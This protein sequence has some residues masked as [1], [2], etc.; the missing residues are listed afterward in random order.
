LRGP[1]RAILCDPASDRKLRAGASPNAPHTRGLTAVAR[2]PYSP[3]IPG[4]MEAQ[5]MRLG[6]IGLAAMLVTALLVQP[7]VAQQSKAVQTMAGMLLTLNHFPNDAQKKTLQ[8]LADDKA[9]TAHERVLLQAL[10]NVQ[11][12]LNAADKPKV[13]ALLKDATASESVKTIATVLSKLN[14]TPTDAEKATLK[15]LAS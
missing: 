3:D 15:K 7:L 5:P 10:M 13:E 4:Q 1:T 11:H 6:C 12:T 2:A 9:T 14:H 8:Q